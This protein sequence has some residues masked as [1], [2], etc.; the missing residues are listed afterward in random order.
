MSNL[1]LLIWFFEDDVK[2]LNRAFTALD[3]RYGIECFDIV[4]VIGGYKLFFKGKEQNNISITSLP[5][6]TNY[7]YVIVSGI[8]PNIIIDRV[9]LRKELAKKIQTSS[10]SI[11]FDFEIY[12]NTFSFPK[13][14]LVVIFNHRFDN[15]LPLLRKIY[16]NRFS[17]IR[18]LMPFYDGSDDDVIPVYE[19]SYSHQGY[20]IQAYEKLKDIPCTHYLFLADDAIIHPEFDEINFIARAKVYDK[21]FLCSYLNPLN[22]PNVFRWWWTPESS[23]PF[24]DYLI[25]WKDS[26]YTYDDAL[27][28]FN[29]FFGFKYKEVYDEA[30]FGDPNKPGKTRFDSWSDA[31]GFEKVKNKFIVTNRNTLHIP[32]PMTFG[33]VDIFCI[34]KESLFEFSRLC[35]IFAAM[36]MFVEIAIPTAAVL[37]YKRKDVVFFQRE[38]FRFMWDGNERNLFADKYGRDFTRLYNEWD[39]KLFVVHP[40][41]LSGWK[42]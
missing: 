29:E 12:D 14:C 5:L 3:S 35:G 19:A 22:N 40:V 25:N 36:N 11:I 30:F 38:S 18:F 6:E 1:K 27:A 17:D 39:D 20:L 33:P 31:E 23:K 32:Y 34:D 8:N 21:K 28:K 10:E 24:Y 42:L 2:P 4:G 37:T 15:N 13:V 16:G 7:D 9:A 41:K 26:I